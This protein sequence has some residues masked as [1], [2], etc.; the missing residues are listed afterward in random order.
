[1]R[2]ALLASIITLAVFAVA[3]GGSNAA[4]SK[5]GEAQNVE[6]PSGEQAGA[7]V[8]FS[9]DGSTIGWTGRKTV[10]GSHDGGFSKFSGNVTLDKAGKE[11]TY[12]VVEIDMNS[13]WADDKDKPNAKLVGHLKADDFFNVEKFPK[14]KFES[15]KIEKKDGNY[16]VTGNL[17]LR[18][19]TKSL[20]F[21]A[22]ISVGDKEVSVKADFQ[23]DRQPY[24]VKFT[25]VGENLVKDQ[26]E[27]RLDVK[28]KR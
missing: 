1:M 5:M 13:I 23:F 16:S 25:G 26:V 9:N 24:G 27:V 12:V 17:T 20:T 10:T 21:D 11:V 15:T 22:A 6:K 2:H 8:K 3:C 14:A 4:N 18:D 7:E 28:A 19:V